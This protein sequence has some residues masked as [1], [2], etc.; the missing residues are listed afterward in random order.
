MLVDERVLCVCYEMNCCVEV[1]ALY[2][3]F[4]GECAPI[5]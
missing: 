5:D 2:I 3:K 4:L 1:E